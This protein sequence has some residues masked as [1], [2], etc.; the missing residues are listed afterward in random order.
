MTFGNERK[1]SEWRKEV[2]RS[3]VCL[4]GRPR[5][6][7]NTHDLRVGLLKKSFPSENGGDLLLGVNEAAHGGARAKNAGSGT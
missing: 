3:K 1:H 2:E 4:Y 5:E 7:E 6:N